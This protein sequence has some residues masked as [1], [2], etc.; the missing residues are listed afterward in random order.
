MAEK[1]KSP[2]N[3][4][5]EQR[6]YKSAN[7]RI[8]VMNGL[9]S[10]LVKTKEDYDNA[11]M[12]MEK[13]DYHKDKDLAD[14]L[15]IFFVD[16]KLIVKYHAF[17]NLEDLKNDEDSK[18]AKETEEAVTSAV[19]KMKEH[20]KEITGSSVSLKKDGKMTLELIATSLRNSGVVAKVVYTIGFDD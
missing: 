20:Y 1:N 11:D 2:E 4:D 7:S 16:D 15:N 13:G 18:F 10:A 12:N 8:S 3:K 5:Y 9:S 6:S 17:V 19:K 14:G